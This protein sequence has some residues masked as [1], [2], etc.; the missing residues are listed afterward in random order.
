MRI[1]IDNSVFGGCFDE[2]FAEWSNDLIAEFEKGVKIAVISDLT[3]RELDN[4]PTHVREILGK[5]PDGSKEYILLGEEAKKLA[6]SYIDEE[7][8]SKN[9]L[10]DAQH[11]AIA[12]VE[13]VDVIVSWNFRHIVNLN[14]IRLYNGVNLKKGYSLLEI[15]S[16]REVIYEKEI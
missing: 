4:A 15:R 11:I 2:E 12:T 14:K 3:L 6:L 13:K 7:V 9:Y 5:I 16:P 10:I 1:Y 8:V